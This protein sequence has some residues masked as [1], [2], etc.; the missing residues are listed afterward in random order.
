MKAIP[1]VFNADAQ[2]AQ[3]PWFEFTALWGF[4]LVAID[5]ACQTFTG[6][7]TSMNVDINDDGTAI[8]TTLPSVATAGTPAT[9]RTKHVGG[10]IDSVYV[11]K[12][13]IVAIDLNFVAGTTPTGTDIACT[14]WVL[15]DA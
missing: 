13:S 11:A 2:G 1:L 7:P 3:A 4:T 5:L 6:A 10:T 14:L 8:V 15:P 12:D 9:W